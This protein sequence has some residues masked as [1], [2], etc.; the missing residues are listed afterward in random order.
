MLKYKEVRQDTKIKS[1]TSRDWPLIQGVISETF[2]EETDNFGRDTSKDIDMF[3]W[4]AMVFS[5][6]SCG[7]H[8]PSFWILPIVC[9]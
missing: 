1:S 7:T 5:A 3:K 9:A 4:L 8:F 6:N 2:S